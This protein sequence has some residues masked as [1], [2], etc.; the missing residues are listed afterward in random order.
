MK[1]ICVMLLKERVHNREKF[2]KS[3]D[4]DEADAKR[5]TEFRV[6]GLTRNGTIRWKEKE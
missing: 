1:G 5:C 4:H 3:S 6:L 2:K